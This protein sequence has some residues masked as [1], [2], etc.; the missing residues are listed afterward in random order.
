ML[1]H[2][3][4]LTSLAFRTTAPL[5]SDAARHSRNRQSK[6]FFKK[7]MCSGVLSLNKLKRSY[8]VVDSDEGR[9][10]RVCTYMVSAHGNL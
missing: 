10:L 4:G 6:E 2:Q 7:T 3:P 1:G 5:W 8:L 9:F